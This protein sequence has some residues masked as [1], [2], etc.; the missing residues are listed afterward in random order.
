MPGVPVWHGAMGA[1]LLLEELRVESTIAPRQQIIGCPL[2][3]HSPL[4]KENQVIGC[5]HRAYAVRNE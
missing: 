5:R 4:L 1:I 2:S 3:C